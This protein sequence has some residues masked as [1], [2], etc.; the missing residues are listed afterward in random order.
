MRDP[1]VAA[2]MVKLAHLEALLRDQEDQHALRFQALCARF[3]DLEDVI[4]EQLYLDRK[5]SARRVRPVPAGS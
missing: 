5:V 1:D 2:M 3:A 4:R